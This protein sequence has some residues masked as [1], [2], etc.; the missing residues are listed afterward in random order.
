MVLIFLSFIQVASLEVKIII[1]TLWIWKLSL[2]KGNVIYSS[3][4]ESRERWS[5]YLSP[6]V[7]DSKVRDVF[8]LLYVFEGSL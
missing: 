6:V 4:R 8:L 1:L 3:F 2:K 7:F 5:C